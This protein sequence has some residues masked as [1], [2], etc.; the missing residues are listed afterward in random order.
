VTAGESGRV[1]DCFSAATEGFV[2]V[3]AAVGPQGWDRPGLGEWTVRDLVGH[4]TRALSTI[5]AYLARPAEEV[6]V[7]DPLDYLRALRGP[8]VQ[9]AAIAQRG[10]EAGAALGDDPLAT[11]QDL[12]GR[13]GALVAATADDATLTTA[14]GG[15]TLLAYLPTRTFEL[16]V[17]TLDLVGALGLVAPD[18]LAAPVAACLELAVA[19]A[20][21]PDGAMLLL[22]VT[23]RRPLPPG[24]SVV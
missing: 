1:R 21:P 8:L 12:A 15:A 7:R 11:V 9:P 20:S 3:V 19:A 24:F 5:E 13:V 18:V 10:R 22:A 2:A 16:T 14:L 4:T 6:V 17:H 23:G